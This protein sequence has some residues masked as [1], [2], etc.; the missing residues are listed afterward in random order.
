[1][2]IEGLKLL[3]FT[4]IDSPVVSRVTA[5][6][7]EAASKE[8]NVTRQ[9]ASSGRETKPSSNAACPTEKPSTPAEGASEIAEEG[10]DKDVEGGA[11]EALRRGERS[12]EGFFSSTRTD[13]AAAPGAKASAC[14]DI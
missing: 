7:E 13:A 4:R 6:R 3:A 2:K 12:R 9:P 10:E 5:Q 1:M 14:G 11:G 8:R